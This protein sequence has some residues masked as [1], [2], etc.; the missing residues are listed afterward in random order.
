MAVLNVSHSVGDFLLIARN[1]RPEPVV[2]SM[3]NAKEIRE[4][5]WVARVTGFCSG[6]NI[7]WMYW[8]ED[9]PSGRLLYHGQL[10]LVS[11]NH[12]GKPSQ[13]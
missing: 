12:G 5:F 4:Y 8:P 3:E 6:Y 7:E 9:L 1:A 10:E 13:R 2:W 11:S